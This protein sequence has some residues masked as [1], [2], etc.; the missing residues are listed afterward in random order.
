[1]RYAPTKIHTETAANLKKG[2]DNR[3]KFTL[4]FVAYDANFIT[5]ENMTCLK[6]R[7]RRV[8]DMFHA[9]MV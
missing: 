3:E 2:A 7:R 6:F 9:R 8:N 4:H 5:K 1:M